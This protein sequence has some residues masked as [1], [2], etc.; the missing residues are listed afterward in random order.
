MDLTQEEFLLI[1]ENFT[2]QVNIWCTLDTPTRVLGL[3]VPLQDLDGNDLTQT[4]QQVSRI[5]LPV[6]TDT[7]QSVELQITSRTIKGQTPNRYYFFTVLTKDVDVLVSPKINEG[8]PTAEVLFTPDIRGGNFFTGNYNV[9]IN[10]VQ[11]SRP[12]EYISASNSAIPANIQDSLYSDTGWVNA[13]Y[14]G[15]PT[16]RD[17]YAS[18]DP[19]I[20][21]K[22]FEATYFPIS[23]L[24]TEIQSIDVTERIYS[25]YFHASLETYP[26]Y[27]LEDNVLFKTFGPQTATSSILTVSTT[28]T[29]TPVTL[30]EPGDL[31]R[32][33][34]SGEVLKVVGMRRFVSNQYNLEVIRGWNNT[35]T[36]SI[37]DNT[38]LIRIESIR[39]FE[40]EKTKPF[41]VRRGKLYIKDT[42]QVL[43]VDRTGY[44]ISGTLPPDL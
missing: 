30:Y 22:S 2:D 43:Y 33:V 34:G 10:T 5:T 20:L 44:I 39:V 41:P 29:N 1:A 42:R 25:E 12:S 38:N 37:S 21:G 17:T 9:V 24:D 4:L 18:I 27:S 3:T 14:N 13:R 19:A 7:R 6:D 35:I 32:P 40:L 31:L 36:S 23:L 26:T 28:S 8:I 15:T 11:E 16:D